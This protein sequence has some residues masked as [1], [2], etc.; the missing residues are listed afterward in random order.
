MQHVLLVL[1]ISLRLQ[2]IVKI[3][4]V[5]VALYNQVFFQ[6]KFIIVAFSF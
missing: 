2:I 6:C 3:N 4:R 5:F 1:Y